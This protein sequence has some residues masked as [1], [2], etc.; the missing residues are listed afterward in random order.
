MNDTESANSPNILVIGSINMDLVLRTPTIPQPGQTVSGHSFATVPGGKGANQAVAAAR[1][2]ANVSMIAKVGND[3]FG[4]RLLLGLKA[5]GIDTSPIMVAEGVSTGIAM[6]TVD[7][8]GE[9]AICLAGEANL[10]LAPSDLDEHTKLIADAD[11]IVMQLEIPSET[12]VCALQLARHHNTPVILNPAPA[13]TEYNANLFDADVIILNQIETAALSGEPVTNQHTAKLAAAAMLTRGANA[14]VVTLGRRGAVALTA[15]N[16]MT[17]PPFD[18]AVNDTT[19][20]GDAFCG[21]F[22]Y[23]YSLHNDLERAARF[24]SAAAALACTKFGAQPSMPHRDAIE[25]VLSRQC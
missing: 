21:A 20:A 6:I 16:S 13:P 5:H 24:A 17:I 19:G 22:A 1:C 14:V 10:K 15:E 2:G 11:V 9:N 12:V 4:N 18:I 23:C 8:K 3:D 25:K 7:E